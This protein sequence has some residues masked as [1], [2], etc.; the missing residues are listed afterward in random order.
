MAVVSAIDIPGIL[1]FAALGVLFV[2][3]VLGDR[4]RG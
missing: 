2:V 1:Y 4:R 3:V